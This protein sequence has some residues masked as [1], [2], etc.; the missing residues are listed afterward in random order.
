MKILCK[1]HLIILEKLSHLHKM[2]EMTF[3]GMCVYDYIPIYEGSAYKTYMN[4]KI[5]ATSI[6]R[7]VV[8]VRSIFLTFHFD[9][10]LDI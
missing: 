3:E 5:M 2:T 1:D 10:I 9:T 8:N 7:R 6:K 4:I